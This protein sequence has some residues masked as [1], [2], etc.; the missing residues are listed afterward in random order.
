M[1][2]RTKIV[3]AVGMG[4]IVL[5]PLVTPPAR[6]AVDRACTAGEVCLYQDNLLVGAN[7]YQWTD[8]D[9]DYRNNKWYMTNDVLDNEAISAKN[10]GTACSVRLFQDVGGTGA[11]VTLSR[12][13]SVPYLGATNLR[14]NRASA[15]MWC[16]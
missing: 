15:H 7:Q 2:I 6:A 16:V 8:N 5:S 4:L 12:N 11:N 9:F 3:T 10:S 13:Q 14:D 1:Q